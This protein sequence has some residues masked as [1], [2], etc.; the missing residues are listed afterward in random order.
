[1]PRRTPSQGSIVSISAP[2][3]R[4]PKGFS[5][6]SRQ[7]TAK[8]TTRRMQWL[9]ENRMAARLWGNKLASLELGTC[10]R[11]EASG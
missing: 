8:E 5:H 11:T 9:A 4:P 10:R 2:P 1:M 6:Q 3:K 7:A